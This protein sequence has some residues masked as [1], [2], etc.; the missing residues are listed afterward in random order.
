MGRSKINKGTIIWMKKITIA[1]EM[2]VTII[3]IYFWDKIY[4]KITHLY[5][6]MRSSTS[7]AVK[8]V[9]APLKKKKLGWLT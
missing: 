2:A 7:I 8:N 4:A 6:L 1:K 9:V 5:F 3:T